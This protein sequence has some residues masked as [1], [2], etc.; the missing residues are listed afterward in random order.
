MVNCDRD[1]HKASEMIS[2][3]WEIIFLIWDWS[4][5]VNLVSEIEASKSMM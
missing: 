5:I 2:G 1:E 4:P 3:L